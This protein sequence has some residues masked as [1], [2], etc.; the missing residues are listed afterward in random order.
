MAQYI[1]YIHI[2]TK[3]DNVYVGITKYSNPN[4]R[5]G[6]NGERYNHCIK[7]MNAI[8]KYGWDTFKHI[9]LCKTTKE[10]AIILEKALIAYYKRKKRSYNIANGGEGTESFSE[11]TRNKLRKYTP[12]IKG[13]H[14][15]EATKELIAEAGRRPC[16]RE[17]RL[18]ISMATKGRPYY[19][20]TEKGRK[21]AIK[22]LSKPVI[23][24]ALDGSYINE[25][26]SATE[27]ER[28]LGVK[29]K[30]ISCCCNGK[31]KTAYGY[32]WSYK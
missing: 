2:N 10:K 19:G 24:Y 17:V 27:A 14:H 1:V 18:K 6:N 30:H 23:Q 31:R 3:T 21:R 4:R 26:P 15:S 11:E 25:F 9:I 16:P 13:K 12:W 20:I 8:N 22:A 28:L 32:K 5:W 29:G 7:F